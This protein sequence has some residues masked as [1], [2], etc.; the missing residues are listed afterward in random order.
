[1]NSQVQK[2]IRAELI[3]TNPTSS[4]LQVEDNITTIMTVPRP[5]TD[6]ECQYMEDMSMEDG[7]GRTHKRNTQ[8][9]AEHYN[10][11]GIDLITEE[12]KKDQSVV[13]MLSDSGLILATDMVA[14]RPIH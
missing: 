3:R 10:L 11:L 5:L 9:P 13:V 14:S 12:W 7:H 2:I 8:L 4:A 6:A 1:M